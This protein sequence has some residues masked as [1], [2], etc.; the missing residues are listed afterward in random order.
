MASSIGARSWG[1]GPS[2]GYDLSEVVCLVGVVNPQF[3]GVLRG[4]FL[5]Q[6]LRQVDD[7]ANTHAMRDKIL[8]LQ[9]DLVICEHD[10]P[11]ESVP[12]M[13]EMIR[14]GE[15]GPNPFILITGLTNGP[16]PE[17]I[18][19]LIQAGVDDLV[20]LP[21][22]PAQIVKRTLTLVEQR[23]Q[24]VVT[25]SYTGPD[26]RTPERNKAQPPAAGMLFDVPNTFRMKATR[27]YD[28]K[29]V[30]EAIQAAHRHS[31]S[32]KAEHHAKALVE[33]ARELLTVLKLGR[34]DTDMRRR[35]G[36][37]AVLSSS[38]DSRVTG[39]GYDHASIL[40][41]AL[42]DVTRR[43]E[44]AEAPDAKDVQLFEKVIQAIDR[45]FDMDPETESDAVR[46]I[47]ETV[48]AALHG[49]S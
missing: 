44:R 20:T 22:A 15:L 40:C 6:G 8:A 14:H 17:P 39:T 19:N 32:R 2:H 29:A 21:V 3:R 48:R 35:L 7:A 43:L 31:N 30:R 10:L 24:F 26:R 27:S 46:A 45:A 42:G 41:S 5:E 38:I 37:L 34:I 13:V 25:G 4:A 16:V 28:E 11:G 1:S 47:A 33:Q 23:K 36:R 18:N 9:P 49:H 12:S